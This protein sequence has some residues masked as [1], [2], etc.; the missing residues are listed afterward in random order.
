MKKYLYI[1]GVLSALLC[2]PVSAEIGDDFAS[3]TLG[4]EANAPEKVEAIIRRTPP[5]EYARIE[6]QLIEVLQDP[7]ATADA[8]SFACRFLQQI[9]SVASTEALAALL[10]EKELSH[11]ARYA[12]ERIPGTEADA[13]LREA[14]ESA[15]DAVKAGIIDSLG[16]RRDAEALKPL[17]RLAHHEDEAIARAAI[18]SIGKIGTAAAFEHLLDIPPLE[19]VA[20]VWKNAVLNC[21]DRL[22]ELDQSETALKMLAAVEHVA[23]VL[24][25]E[26]TQAAV[27]RARLRADPADAVPML[28]DLIEQEESVMRTAAMTL[29]ASEPSHDLS[30]GISQRLPEWPPKVQLRVLDGLGHRGDAAAL[31]GVIACLDSPQEAVREIAAVTVG[32]LGDASHVTLLLEQAAEGVNTAAEAVARIHD[33]R[34]GAVLAAALRESDRLVIH[35]MRAVQAVG[36]TTE[37]VPE[38]VALL[39]DTDSE[40][41][42][43]AWDILQD[44][45]IENHLE[46][47]MRAM[48]EIE[49]N[50]T[51]R[52]AMRVL[53]RGFD[54]L[55]EKNEAVRVIRPFYRGGD[56]AVREFILDVV[57]RTG[58]VDGLDLMLE[59]LELETDEG[60]LRTKAERTAASL[61]WDMRE[62]APDRSAAV[63]EKIKAEGVD[64]TARAR[65]EEILE[66][67]NNE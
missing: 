8:K 55:E 45:R 59:A 29:L 57:E 32:R 22:M 12:L 30:R 31:P 10:T 61:S 28:V 43:K 58:A 5:D 20:D 35:A 62:T 14:L 34:V 11:Y 13:A 42:D 16:E 47:V 53:M 25:D 7:D 50:R 26:K 44:A 33:E 27:L 48:T 51:K 1:L 38:V 41:R 23:D 4:D 65:A 67:L 37:T 54:E 21:A 56:D 19:A 6:D 17:A 60:E 24:D 2:R 64:D 49:D 36:T 46:E 66:A 18:D 63:A 9:G 3:Y 15:P 39:S 52:V 40:I